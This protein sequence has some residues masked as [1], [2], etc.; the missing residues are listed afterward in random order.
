MSGD[1]RT[2]VKSRYIGGADK[3]DQADTSMKGVTLLAEDA[4][5]VDGS[6]MLT[7]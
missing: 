4:H 3:Q 1:T 6:M 2:S 7:I 5:T